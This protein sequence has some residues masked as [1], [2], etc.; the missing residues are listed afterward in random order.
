MRVRTRGEGPKYQTFKVAKPLE[1]TLISGDV[2]PG[3]LHYT[4]FDSRPKT[5]GFL[6]GVIR[7]GA[8]I[9]YT[10]SGDTY[11]PSVNLT[12]NVK[13]LVMADVLKQ[14]PD[15]VTYRDVV[16]L[17]SSET[18]TMTDTVTPGFRKRVNAGEII[19]NPME[20]VYDY[21]MSFPRGFLKNAYT[22]VPGG[23]GNWGSDPSYRYWHFRCRVKVDG[24]LA[25]HTNAAVPA[26]K[27]RDTTEELDAI[28]NVYSK[29]QSAELDVAL[30]VAEGSETLTYIRQLCRRIM[31]LI[32]LA[33]NRRT[34]AQVATRTWRRL[35]SLNK[36][37]VWESK[38]IAEAWLEVRYAIRPLM[39]DIADAI[40]YFE[41]GNKRTGKRT[42]FRSK[43]QTTSTKEYLDESS[44]VVVK[45]TY[46]VTTT[47]RAGCIAERRL[48]SQLADL[49]FLN[50]AG[51]V[52]EKVK[53]SFI[54]DWIINISGLL[55]MLNPKGTWSPLGA[56]VKVTQEVTFSGTIRYDSL[57]GTS[58]SVP[59]VGRRRSTHRSAVSG[60]PLTFISVNIDTFKMLDLAA[61]ARGLKG[62]ISLLR[63]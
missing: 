32:E 8:D 34:L 2:G 21:M 37:Y 3:Y 47:A 44:S 25:Q 1:T 40:E 41:K 26:P 55:Y 6:G 54:L 50:L 33:T 49:G 9:T 18:E 61:L 7:D 51:V 24:G 53:F 19:I 30:M 28:A 60:P 58:I 17:V 46:D 27:S 52:W 14:M 11:Y 59:I 56:W 12:D 63:L 39:Y 13:S 10:R 20:Q 45:Y 29:L 23:S 36:N 48:T 31:R 5:Y 62:N 22:V 16:A 4:A 35:R 57:D 38:G 43:V 42:T 15:Y